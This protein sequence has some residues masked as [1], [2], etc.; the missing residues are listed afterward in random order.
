MMM[1]KYADEDEEDAGEAKLLQLYH[2]DV[3]LGRTQNYKRTE[4]YKTKGAQ[5]DHAKT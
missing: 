1:T 5:A 4:T 2:K 3:V